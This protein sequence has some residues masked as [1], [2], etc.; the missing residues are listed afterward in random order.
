MRVQVPAFADL[1]SATLAYA[2]TLADGTS[3]PAWLNFDAAIRSFSGT[4]PA[5]RSSALDLRVGASDGAAR[6]SDTFRLAIT[7]VND[8][9]VA[10]ADSFGSAGQAPVRDG[11]QARIDVTALPAT[12]RASMAAPHLAGIAPGPGPGHAGRGHRR[13]PDVSRLRVCGPQLG[14]GATAVDTF[15]YSVVDA[16]GATVTASA[17]LTVT[18]LSTRTI[19]GTARSETLTG[20]D[21]LHDSTN[22]K[23]GD[24]VTHGGASRDRLTS[25]DGADVFL[26]KQGAGQD[27]TA[28]LGIG[29][30]HIR[31][32]AGVTVASAVAGHLNHDRLL[33]TTL[34]LSCGGTL[35]VMDVAGPS[36]NQ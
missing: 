5:N 32:G 27:R 34:A 25:E 9:P 16:S 31:L 7:P 11:A 10:R 35:E 21:L 20:S 14:A 13:G 24:D 30:D 19:N 1:D 29:R 18:G 36:A 15:T 17:S 4:P 8:A 28:D 3:L 2:A 23:N 6:A 26:F 12:T 22:G 33:D